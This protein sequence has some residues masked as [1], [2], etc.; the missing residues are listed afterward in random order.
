MARV[1][2][3][4]TVMASG[5]PASS[6]SPRAAAPS[7]HGSDHSRSSV[8][9]TSCI[10]GNARPRRGFVSVSRPRCRTGRI[11]STAGGATA[12]RDSAR[13][14]RCARTHPT[15]ADLRDPSRTPLAFSLSR[16]ENAESASLPSGACVMLFGKHRPGTARSDWT[17]VCPWTD[18]EFRADRLGCAATIRTRAGR[19]DARRRGTSMPRVPGAGCEAEQERWVA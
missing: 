10:G 2:V 15:A 12:Y 7:A 17:N 16:K 9:L 6:S 1:L 5:T 13:R 18:Q 4:L 19:G 3:G 11:Y 14:Q 8:H